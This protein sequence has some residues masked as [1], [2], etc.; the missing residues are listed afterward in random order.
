MSECVRPLTDPGIATL[1]EVLDSAALRKHLRGISLGSWDGEAVE[2]IQTR[3]LRHQVGRRCTLEIGLR[4]ESGWQFLIGK[5]YRKDRPEFFPAMEEI[6]QAG[7]GPH[8]EFSIP[9]PLAYVPSLRLLLQ[10]KVEGPVAKEIFKTGDERRRAATAERCALWLARFH[11]LA[12]H[13]GPNSAPRDYLNSKRMRKC[14][15]E[16][17]NLDG[18][19]AGKA[20][21]L[22][23]LLEAAASSLCPVDMC[24]GHGAYRPDH[25]ILSQSRTVVFDFDTQDVADPARDVA[26]FLVALRRIALELGSIRALDDAAEVF[27]ETY[28]GASQPGV[29]RN[30]RFFEAAACL[31]RARRTLS[32]RVSHWRDKTE[33][34][35]D[36]GLRVLE[37]EVA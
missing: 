26:R 4:T 36:E 1:A 29:E 2:E 18:N 15:G 25:V 14:R 20:D 7:F 34:M 24:A 16:I 33:A 11:A 9:Q 27:L 6:Q 17:S 21:R 10:E 22:Q 8:E 13:A 35:L 23:R 28:L 37:R 32:R 3:L 5:V 19:F 12:P 31:K 30:L